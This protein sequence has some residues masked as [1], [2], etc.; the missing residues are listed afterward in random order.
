MEPIYFGCF[1]LWRIASIKYNQLKHNLCIDKLIHAKIS[2][3]KNLSIEPFY[4]RVT[5]YQS[6]SEQEKKKKSVSI[7]ENAIR[8][9]LKKKKKI[10]LMKNY[11]LAQKKCIFS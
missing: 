11:Y 3:N 4:P 10:K 6:L 2:K 9:F 8:I 5:R 1:E 7:I